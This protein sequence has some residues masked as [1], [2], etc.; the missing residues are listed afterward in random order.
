MS[1]KN[2]DAA[3]I[4]CNN[5]C[6]QIKLGGII[7]TINFTMNTEAYSHKIHTEQLKS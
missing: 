3:L 2:Y 5:Y 1:L 4:Y 6:T 7:M